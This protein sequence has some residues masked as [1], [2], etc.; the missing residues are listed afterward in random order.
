MPARM[1]F[2]LTQA[3]TAVVTRGTGT[4]M[5]YCEIVGGPQWKYAADRKGRAM[6]V[7]ISVSWQFASVGMAD[8]SAQQPADLGESAHQGDGPSVNPIPDQVLP[9]GS[10]VVAPG[11]AVLMPA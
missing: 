3:E 8:R 10:S 11:L 1:R 6:S 9:L 4:T 7:K 5:Y 2:W